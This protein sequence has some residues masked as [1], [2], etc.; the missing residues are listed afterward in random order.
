MAMRAIAL[1]RS[2]VPDNWA[3]A[4][5]RLGASERPTAALP[6]RG[7]WDAVLNALDA[8][9]LPGGSVST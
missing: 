7:L 1:C 9:E 2:C 8:I 5:R 3:P 4:G 6:A